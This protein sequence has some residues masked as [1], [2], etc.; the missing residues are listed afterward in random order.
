MKPI[1]ILLIEDDNDYILILGEYLKS[2]GF[3]STLETA[4]RSDEAMEKIKNNSF[5]CVLTDYIVPTASGLDI[6]N[7]ARKLGVTTPFIF[8]TGFGDGGL[9]DELMKR[10]AADFIRKDELDAE[11]LAKKILKAVGGD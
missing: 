9:G 1:R 7:E 6:M 4:G 8:L 11:T 5:D 10:G 3:E 2:A